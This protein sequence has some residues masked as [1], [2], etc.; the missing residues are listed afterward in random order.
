MLTEDQFTQWQEQGYLLLR[1]VLEPWR[2]QGVADIYAQQVDEILNE[3]KQAGDIEDTR[4]DLP[5]EERFTIAGPFA[6]RY[7][8]SWRTLVTGREVFELHNDPGLTRILAELIGD[9][10][11][12][13]P[14]YNARPKLPGQQLTVV[15]WH[16]DTAYFGEGSE[17]SEILTVWTPMVPVDQH[18]GCLQVVPGSH[19]WGVAK[20]VKEQAEGEFLEIVGKE[21]SDDQILTCA[22]QPGDL[23][24]FNNLTFHRSLPS[25]QLPIRWSIDMRFLRDGD[26]KFGWVD[27]DESFEWIVRSN[28]PARP[29]TDFAT[30]EKVFADLPQ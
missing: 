21:I 12:A 29:V 16:Q 27:L 22:M 5:F 24:I 15:P 3:L 8:R 7:G 10:V 28:D 4:P 6:K 2:V 17:V 13:H 19:Q 1:N 18:N 23:L 26:K 11:I 9:P 20:H 30:W 25:T 14:A